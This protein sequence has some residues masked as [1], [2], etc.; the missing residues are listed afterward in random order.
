[1]TKLEINKVIGSRSTK[2]VV[3]L[4]LGQGKR[5]PKLKFK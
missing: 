3:E 2:T 1:M 4:L 5:N